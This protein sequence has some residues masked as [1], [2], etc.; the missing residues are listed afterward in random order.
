MMP[1][2]I[3]RWCFP[4]RGVALLCFTR[5]AFGTQTRGPFKRGALLLLVFRHGR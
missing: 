5:E 1:L 4:L 3:L 2:S